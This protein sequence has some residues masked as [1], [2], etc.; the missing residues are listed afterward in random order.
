MLR[1]GARFVSVLFAILFLV[2]GCA[3]PAH[4]P[5]IDLQRSL[6]PGLSDF[7]P[8][9]IESAFDK[10]LELSPPL[11]AGIAWLSEGFGVE[12]TGDTR[13]SEYQRTGVIKTAVESLR[14]PPFSRVI[15]IPTVLAE[16][17]SK[18]REDSINAIRSAVA[19]FQLDVVI[20]L[21]TAT[22]DRSGLNPAALGYIF[23]IT[24]PFV[25]GEDLSVASTAEMCAVDVRSGIMM[26]CSRGRLA[27]EDTFVSTYQKRKKL[28]EMKESTLKASVEEAASDLLGQISMRLPH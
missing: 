9:E 11:S 1:N 21:Q 28:D 5:R 12:G 4:Y 7:K 16:K 26:D 27:D 14:Q 25:P 24:I 2:S 20:L 13:L 6:F 3:S 19:H 23:L 15:S 8:S 18:T 17:G 10:K 22:E